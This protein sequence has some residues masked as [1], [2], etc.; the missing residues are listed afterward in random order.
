VRRSSLS[1]EII[2]AKARATARVSSFFKFLVVSTLKRHNLAHI[3]SQESLAAPFVS[4]GG[5]NRMWILY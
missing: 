5:K 4:D 3:Q 1:R 2:L